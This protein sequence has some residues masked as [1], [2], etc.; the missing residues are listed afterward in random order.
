MDQVNPLSANPQKWSNTLKQF[1]EFVE[2]TLKG[3]IKFLNYTGQWANLCKKIDVSG[4][5]PRFV[6]NILHK[7]KPLCKKVICN[8]KAKGFTFLVSQFFYYSVLRRSL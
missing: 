1:V 4:N 6:R 3:L 5:I 8:T 7:S 2:L